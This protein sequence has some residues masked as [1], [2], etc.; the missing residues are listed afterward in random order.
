[1]TTVESTRTSD[2]NVEAA[3]ES[4][5][6]VLGTKVRI[7]QGRKGGRM[8]LHYHSEDELQ[9]IYSLIYQAAERQA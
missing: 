4:L 8:E 9:R 7:I 5:Q 6:S 2:P 1:M 3:V